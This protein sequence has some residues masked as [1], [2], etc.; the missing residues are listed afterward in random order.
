M[1]E[2]VVLDRKYIAAQNGSMKSNELVNMTA[3]E[4]EEWLKEEQSE[5][6]GWD[7]GDGSGETVDNERQTEANVE[8]KSFDLARTNSGRKIIEVL[9]K[10]PRKL[11]SR[12]EEDDLGH[13]REV[14]SYYKRH[15]AQEKKAKQDSDS[16]CYKSLKNYTSPD[17]IPEPEPQKYL[18]NEPHT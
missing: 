16:K 1:I 11:P 2:Y 8:D 4:L 14:V 5:N 9:N 3:A 18:G 13:M 12:Y 6:S 15:L 7:K 17:S 10:N